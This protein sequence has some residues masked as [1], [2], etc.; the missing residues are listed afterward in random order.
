MEEVCVYVCMFPSCMGLFVI[1]AGT[2]VFVCYMS[3][4]VHIGISVS[5][6]F[7]CG[8][9]LDYVYEVMCVVYVYVITC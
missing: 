1:H 3:I 5:C 4:T 9:Y 2:Y 6:V 7:F 8:I